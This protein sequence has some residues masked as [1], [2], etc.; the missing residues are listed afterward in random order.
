MPTATDPTDT[1]PSTGPST[2][3]SAETSVATEVS[4]ASVLTRWGTL[5]LLVVLLVASLAVLGW[6]LARNDDG[7]SSLSSERESAM[8]FADRFMRTANTY[9]PSMLSKN[10]KTMP[11]YRAAVEKMLTAK[12]ATEFEQTV[13]YAEAIVANNDVKRTATVFQT[14]VAAIDDDTA[15]VLVAGQYT[16]SMPKKG[17]SK[18]LKEQ[19][20][21]RVDVDLVK[22]HGAWKVD[23]W[24]ASEKAPTSNSGAGVAQ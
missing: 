9:G 13:P 1:G 14:G 3:E 21:F 10:R 2:E 20:L 23:N 19:Q 4:S 11:S 7:D 12:F 18:P 16:L 22:T 8:A 6:H 24:E 15:T 17:S 5:A